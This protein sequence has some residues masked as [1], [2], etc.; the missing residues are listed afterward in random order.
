MNASQKVQQQQLRGARQSHIWHHVSP[1]VQGLQAPETIFGHLGHIYGHHG[2]RSCRH[3]I[4]IQPRSLVP[5]T[6]QRP[7]QSEEIE[8][9]SLSFLLCTKD[10]SS[11]SPSATVAPVAFSRLDVAWV[12]GN[13]APNDAK[14]LSPKVWLLQQKRVQVRL[15][16]FEST[17]AGIELFS[18]F[19]GK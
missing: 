10:S 17:R 8:V 9:Y 12:G 16:W 4:C 14:P 19:D 7:K 18:N 6:R 11:S 5:I 3:L 2:H 1:A 15:P 13:L